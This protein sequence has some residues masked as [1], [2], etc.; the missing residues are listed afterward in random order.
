MPTGYNKDGTHNGVKTRFPKGSIPYNK[1][2]KGYSTSK[3]GKKYPQYSGKNHPM[4]GKKHSLE[5]LEKMKKPRKKFTPWNKGKK[6]PEISER[7]TGKH[8]SEATK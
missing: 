8:P 6:C 3:K 5:T 4:Y 1:G 7:L 2:I